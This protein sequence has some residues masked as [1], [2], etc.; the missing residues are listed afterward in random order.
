[1]KK[2]LVA[3]GIIVALGVVWTGGAWYTGKQLEGRIADMVQ[4]ANAQLR[5]SAPESGLELS[6]QN[7]QRGLFSSHLQL[8]VKPIAGQANSWLATGQSVVLDEV[9]DHGPFPLASLKT[10]NLAPAMA[11]VHTTLVKN[12]ASQALF[13]IAKGNTPFTVDTRIAYSGDSQSAIVLNA[14]EKVTFS[15]GQFQL[16][17]DRDGKNISLK[18]QAG[19][20]QIDALNEY[21]QKV[22]LRFVNL[23]TDG[24]TELASFNERIGQQKMTLDKLAISVEGNSTLTQDGK[25]VNS[26]VNYTVNSLKLQGQD[27]GSG[28]LTLKVDNVDGQAW[29]QFS[30]QYSAQSQ[31]L[32]AKPELAQNPEL[33]Q[34]ALTETLFNALPILLKGNPSVTISPLSWRNA[35][36]ESTLNLSVLL[37]DPAQVTTPPQ[38]LADSLDRVVQSLDGKVVIPVDM[39]TEL[40]TKI[41]GLEGYQPADAAKLAD[42]QVKGLAAMGQ[43]FRITTME[44]N[45]ISSSLQYANG[46]VTLNGQKMPLE[47]FAA[48]FG[49]EAPAQ[50]DAAP[51]EGQPQQDDAAP[52][53]DDAAPQP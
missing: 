49:L 9:V 4:Q 13:E 51:Q 10:F 19:S 52:Q 16:D 36:G 12:D 23:T 15:G 42:Q 24:A 7:Y 1:M 2:S 50:P 21:N 34:Q 43:M 6:Y 45:A 48:M 35:K 8:V 31:A 47:D 53:Q 17:A 14:D 29:H 5:S 33:Y 25:G 28:K 20:G 38:T 22:Q 18:G 32:L 46:Q 41:A 26:Q 3:A 37:K 39:A 44:D 11:S 40:M 27:M 30:Q